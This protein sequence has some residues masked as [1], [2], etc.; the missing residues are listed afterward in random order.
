MP[1][2]KVLNRFYQ[3]L[4]IGSCVRIG[5]SALRQVA[6]QAKSFNQLC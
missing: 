5:N 3:W 2:L 1:G 6:K 4:I